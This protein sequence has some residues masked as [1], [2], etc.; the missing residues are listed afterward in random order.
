MKLSS[1]AS[2]AL[3][4]LLI[5]IAFANQSNAQTPPGEAQLKQ[6]F[7]QGFLKGCVSGTTPGVKDQRGYCNCMVNSYQSRY[8]GQTLA[9]ISQ[10]AGTSGNTGPVLVNLMMSPEA[11]TCRARSK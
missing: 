11:N 10:L 3:T 1:L 5:P 2:I 8:D 6:Q 7:S 4:A 9:A